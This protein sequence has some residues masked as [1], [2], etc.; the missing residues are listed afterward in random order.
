MDPAR[1][2]PRAPRQ[3]VREYSDV[4]SA[5]APALATLSSLIL[6]HANTQMMNRF[7]QHVGQEYAAYFIVMQ[8]DRVGWHQAKDVVIPDTIRLL[9]QPG[10]SPELNPVEHIWEELRE[11]QFH[12][13]AFPSLDAVEAT[14]I[15]ALNQLDQAPERVRAMTYFP[16]FRNLA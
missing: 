3:V 16:H 1:R 4:F 13:R 10:H 9:P 7:L 12:N 15:V 2:R 14:L 8:V 11:Q 6:P 5:V